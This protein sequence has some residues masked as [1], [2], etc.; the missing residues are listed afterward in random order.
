MNA[1]CDA[2]T[3]GKN[4]VDDAAPGRLYPA[5]YRDTHESFASEMSFLGQGMHKQRPRLKKLSCLRMSELDLTLESTYTG[6]TMA[7]LLA[8]MR[9]PES[10]SLNLLYWHTYNS[11]HF[12][13][14]ADRPLDEAALPEEFLKYFS[15]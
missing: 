1:K 8:D 5:E 6:K 9:K 10:E 14:P 4:S 7:A 11:V 13:V 2:D 15:A 3:F 12:D